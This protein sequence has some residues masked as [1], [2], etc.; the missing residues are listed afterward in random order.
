MAKSHSFWMIID[1][2]VPTAFRARDREDLLPTLTQLKRTQPNVVLMWFERGR[3]WESPAAARSALEARRQQPRSRDRKPDWRPG[4]DH[5][6][7]RAKYQISRDEKRARFKKRQEF[8]R[9]RDD[10]PDGDRTPFRN[11]DRPG[12]ADRRPPHP[13]KDRPSFQGDRRPPFSREGRP[14]RENRP[15]FARENRPRPPRGDRPPFPRETRPPTGRENRPP[16]SRD[17]RPPF[18]RDGKPPAPR[19]RKPFPREGR[20]PSYGDWR[21]PKGRGGAH[22]D[23][24]RQSFDGPRREAPRR[25]RDGSD[26]KKRRKNGEED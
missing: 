14:P 24:G 26:H 20:G 25:P 19:D 15:P 22:S 23:R 18:P 3:V 8:E 13:R 11:D 1:G 21:P 4:G 2:A 5:R 9:R 10:R 7:P 6:D 12:R 16:S 17:R